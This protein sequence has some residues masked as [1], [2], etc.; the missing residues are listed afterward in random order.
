MSHIPE[1]ALIAAAQAA[2]AHSY[3]PYSRYAV[4]A[5]VLT[6]A[7]QVFTGCNIENASYG[8][9]VC[10]ERVAL[11]KAV[12]EGERDFEAIAIVTDNGGSPCGI[13]R[14]V[15]VEFAPTMK[16]IIADTS[17][18]VRVTTVDDL[19]PDRF[20]ADDLISGQA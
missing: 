8:A 12:S 15:M 16:V 20:T 9:T 6:R 19:L 18:N 14:Q 10:A 3:S 7:G 1:A 17:G 4:G 2:R 13:C 5:A 11:W